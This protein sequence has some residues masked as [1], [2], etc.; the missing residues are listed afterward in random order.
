MRTEREG[1]KQRQ[2]GRESERQ[3][4]REREREGERRKNRMRMGIEKEGGIHEV[5]DGG[6]EKAKL[7]EENVRGT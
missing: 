1:G 6:R 3:R 2:R 4:E 5:M 7:A